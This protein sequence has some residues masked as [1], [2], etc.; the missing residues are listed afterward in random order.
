[1]LWQPS[2]RHPKTRVTSISKNLLLISMKQNLENVNYL[3]SKTKFDSIEPA[4]KISH[5]TTLTF[6]YEAKKQH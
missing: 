3:I 6:K 2:K 1:M 4:I 5:P